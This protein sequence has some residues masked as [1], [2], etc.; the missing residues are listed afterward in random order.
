MGYAWYPSARFQC[1]S[2]V[3]AASVVV[4]ALFTSSVGC[5]DLVAII[6]PLPYRGSLQSPDSFT[7]LLHTPCLL[8]SGAGLGQLWAPLA[9]V[10]ICIRLKGP[11]ESHQRQG[12]RERDRERGRERD[13]DT[14]FA[15][16]AFNGS[17]SSPNASALMRILRLTSLSRLPYLRPTG[18]ERER[19][20]RGGRGPELQLGRVTG[21]F[22]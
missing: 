19:G 16:A 14:S 3:A 9:C 21:P 1:S 17:R 2:A 12:E 5:F 11:F 22:V 4:V 13:T 18:R 15:L 8:H 6:V 7:P 10:Y 20:E